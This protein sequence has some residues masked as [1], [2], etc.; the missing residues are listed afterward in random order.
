VE[1]IIFWIWFIMTMPFSWLIVSYANRKNKPITARE[2]FFMFYGA[3][4]VGVPIYGI[5]SLR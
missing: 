3:I 1:T 5:M 2:L 4:L